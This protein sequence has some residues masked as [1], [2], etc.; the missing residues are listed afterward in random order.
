VVY[1]DQVKAARLKDVANSPYRW[2]A[3]TMLCFLILFYAHPEILSF[4]ALSQA[5][6]YSIVLL[7][8]L[9]AMCAIIA[10]LHEYRTAGGVEWIIWLAPPVV[11][12]AFW[13]R[14]LSTVLLQYYLWYPSWSSRALVYPLL[15]VAGLLLSRLRYP[16]FLRLASR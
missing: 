14:L 2:A 15:L 11:E 12:L 5:L 16:A 13:P 1:L 3:T 10:L 8:A 9:A 6:V 4:L 7:R